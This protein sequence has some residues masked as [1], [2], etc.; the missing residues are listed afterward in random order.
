MA[1]TFSV[2]TLLILLATTFISF[3][4]NERIEHE[5]QRKN[6]SLKDL[7]TIQ[8]ELARNDATLAG[9]LKEIPEIQEE[10]R[11][12][13]EEEA[14]L[15]AISAK[16]KSDLETKTRK[17]TSNEREFEETKSTLLLVGEPTEL[18]PKAKGMT[19]QSQELD[20]LITNKESKLANLNA[21]NISAAD[22]GARLKENLD[23]IGRGDS[24]PTLKTRIRHIYPNWGFV[25]LANG[26]Q[27]GVTGGS[28]LDIMRDG[29]VIGKLLVSTVERSSAS[30]SIVPDSIA[31]DITLRVGDQ[32]VATPKN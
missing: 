29:K 16:L 24:L 28:S 27:S 18:V 6:T 13:L 19:I 22:L 25:T 8:D 7:K 4:N 26:Y 20:V 10:T 5:I 21:E 11:L 3:K 1:T 32:V 15:Q 31:E 14:K 9:L 2:L 23:I 17:I 30:A 12:A